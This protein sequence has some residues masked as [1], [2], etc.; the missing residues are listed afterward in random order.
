MAHPKDDL[1]KLFRSL[2]ADDADFQA[3]GSASARELEQR[4]PLFRA[5]SPA[6]AAPTPAL[7]EE[8]RQRWTAGDQSNNDRGTP[9]LT[10]PGLADK[11]A[12][13]LG[14][15]SVRMA[16]VPPAPIAVKQA[17]PSHPPATPVRSIRP[18]PNASQTEAHG[19]SASSPPQVTSV[20]RESP[21]GL[22]LFKAPATTAIA[23][24]P[25]EM[26]DACEDNSLKGVFKRLEGA[27]KAKVVASPDA[28]R[29]S[30]L[31][32]LGRR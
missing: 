21:T 17:A 12:N 26:A 10:L 3:D 6:K 31:G 25:H 11:L 29:S 30:F 24:E 9:A 23:S 19:I 20:V 18:P 1:P 16:P 5:M 8:E 13:S 4:W 32:R 15:M 27:E 14:K 22:G 2:G 7:T 28:K